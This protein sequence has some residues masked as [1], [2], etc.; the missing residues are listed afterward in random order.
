MGEI[1]VSGEH[2]DRLLTDSSGTYGAPYQQAFA[3]LARMHRGRP[4]PE[5]LPLLARA[6]DRALLGFSRAGLREQ[7]R[8]ISGGEPYVLRVTVT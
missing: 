7:A 8:A 3:E 5:I 4:A 2:L 6:A 1:S